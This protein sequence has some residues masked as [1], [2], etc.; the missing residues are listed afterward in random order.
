LD[1]LNSF[2]KNIEL[3]SKD[4]VIDTS[5]CVFK[6]KVLFIDDQADEGW[7]EAL[8]SILYD[9]NGIDLYYIGDELKQKSREEIIDLVKKKV[10]SYSPDIV[11]LDLRLCTSDF[12]N[13]QI[14][15][16]TGNRVLRA[17]KQINRG[18]QVLMFSATNKVWNYQSLSSREGNLDGADGFVVKE[19]PK[20]SKDPSYTRAIIRS[21]VSD[22][23]KCCKYTYRKELWK[24]LQDDIIKCNTSSSEYGNA[25]ARLL[26]LAE[27]SLFAKQTS[28]PY[29]SIFMNL[30]RVL[31]ATANKYIDDTAIKDSED[32]HYFKFRD[33]TMLSKFNRNGELINGE[34]FRTELRS[35]PY[36][37]KICNTLNYLGAYSND[38][39][40][41]VMKRNA[42][43]HP[44][45]SKQDG[46]EGFG[47]EEVLKAF[48]LVHNLI[49]NQGKI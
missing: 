49:Q 23:S 7:Y 39:Y 2:K 9:K 28:F 21:F 4:L 34:V 3:N 25:V 47:V 48:D 31:E 24:K 1:S 11:I 26:E 15:E 44:D 38:V 16:L 6:P 12:D 42:F 10:S 32:Q 14:K 17:I 8:C 5:C 33:G 36:M 19:R 27:D 40:N 13:I 35:L 22:L 29:A 45:M 20:D 43:T 37:Q 18:I 46:L 41:L 30:F